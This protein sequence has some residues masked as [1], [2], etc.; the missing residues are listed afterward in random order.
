ML[1]LPSPQD[2]AAGTHEAQRQG[3]DLVLPGWHLLKLLDTQ[4]RRKRPI[5]LQIRPDRRW[6]GDGD[7]DKAARISLQDLVTTKKLIA[8]CHCRFSL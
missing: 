3:F 2:A 8:Q 6:L 7:F 5:D 4:H 1:T